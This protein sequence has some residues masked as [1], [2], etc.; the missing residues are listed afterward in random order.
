MGWPVVSG[1]LLPSLGRH[2]EEICQ[3]YSAFV[4][5]AV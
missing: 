5:E 2:N 1:L 4:N 3:T